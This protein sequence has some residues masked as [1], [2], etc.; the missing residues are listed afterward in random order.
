[1]AGTSRLRDRTPAD[2]PEPRVPILAG[3]PHRDGATTFTRDGT[4][5]RAPFPGLSEDERTRHK[6]ELLYPNMMLSLS[7]DHVAAF[8]LWP[9]APGRTLIDCDFLFHPDEIARPGSDPS[10]AVEFWDLV[11]R[12]DWRICEAVQDGMGSTAFDTGFYA[13]MEDLSLDIRRYV[14]DRLGDAAV[15]GR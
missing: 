11:N 6:G 10:D 12:Q 3:V 7:S 5:T 9:V 4:T 14:A 8:T 2:A 13:P 1:L 15:E